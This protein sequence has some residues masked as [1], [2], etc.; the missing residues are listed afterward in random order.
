MDE[1]VV[2]FHSVQSGDFVMNEVLV[3]FYSINSGG[4]RDG[5]C[6]GRVPLRQFWRN[7]EMDVG[8]RGGLLL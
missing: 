6:S 3:V 2:V 1:V 4:L 5:W 8:P 7:S